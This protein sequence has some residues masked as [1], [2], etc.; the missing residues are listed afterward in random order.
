MGP[1]VAALT[2]LVLIVAFVLVRPSLVRKPQPRTKKTVLELACTGW[3][4]KKLDSA[5]WG[6][7]TIPFPFLVVIFYWIGPGMPAVPALV[8]V[9]EFVH[10]A[11]DER[12]LF[13]LVTW[14]KYLYESFYQRVVHTHD[15]MQAYRQNRYETEAYMVEYDVLDGRAPMPAWAAE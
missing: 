3:L 9:H 10:V 11:Q 12:N 4:A 8:R 1:A 14:V 2:V 15:W 13:F 7:F 5:N 6:A